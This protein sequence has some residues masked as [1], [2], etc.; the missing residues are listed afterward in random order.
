MTTAH[1]IGAAL[2]VAILSPV[3]TVGFP[4]RIPHG[5]SR[6]GLMGAAVLAGVVAALTLLTV[7]SADWHCSN[8]TSRGLS[9]KCTPRTASES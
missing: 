6:D 7:P 9:V 5:L 1:E 3:A 4:S 2:G 8:G